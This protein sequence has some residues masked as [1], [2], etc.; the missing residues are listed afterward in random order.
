MNS[1]NVKLT[2]NGDHEITLDPGRAITSDPVNFNLK[3]RMDLA[4]TIYF[5]DT[6]LDITGHPGS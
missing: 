6:S 2:F 1:T 5:G 3:P 4:I